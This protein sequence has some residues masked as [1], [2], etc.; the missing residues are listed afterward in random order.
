LNLFSFKGFTDPMTGEGIHLS[1][2]GG[3]LAAY[4]LDEA[5][6]VGNFDRAVMEEYQNRWINTF[7]HDFKW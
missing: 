7:G 5:L 2:E 4:F 1:M 6:S 3:R